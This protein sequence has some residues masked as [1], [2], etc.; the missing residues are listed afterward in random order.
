M[1]LELELP[2]GARILAGTERVEFGSLA[3]GSRS[4]RAEWI[5]LA[6]AGSVVRLRATSRWC[7]TV[8]KELRP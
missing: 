4:A 2:A 5:L 3:G 7:P 1:R 8:E 6:P